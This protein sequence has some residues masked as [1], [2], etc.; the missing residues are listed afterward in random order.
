MLRGGEHGR[1][2]S[3]GVNKILPDALSEVKSGPD[4]GPG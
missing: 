2:L 3:I 1:L 4:L